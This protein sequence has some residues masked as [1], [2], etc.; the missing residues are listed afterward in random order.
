MEK[1]QEQKVFLRRIVQLDFKI[2]KEL[3]I[4]LPLVFPLIIDLKTIVSGVIIAKEVIKTLKEDQEV[5]IDKKF[6]CKIRL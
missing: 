2:K 1:I 4:M 3:I 5:K 6:Q